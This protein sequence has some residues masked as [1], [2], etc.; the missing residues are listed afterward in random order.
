[1][2][3]SS[4]TWAIS[5]EMWPILNQQHEFLKCAFHFPA[6]IACVKMCKK[7]NFKQTCDLSG[8]LNIKNELLDVQ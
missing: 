4:S 3:S 5:G 8:N 6:P 1:M 7:W 2:T